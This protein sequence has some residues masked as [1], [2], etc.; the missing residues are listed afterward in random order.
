MRSEQALSGA[1]WELLNDQAALSG[2]VEPHIE[3]EAE[4]TEKNY[5]MF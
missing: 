5:C 3:G 2:N 4:K 1:G